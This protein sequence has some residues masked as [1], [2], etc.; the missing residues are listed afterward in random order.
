MTVFYPHQGRCHLWWG[1]TLGHLTATAA[2]TTLGPAV[3]PYVTRGGVEENKGG[4]HCAKC[5]PLWRSTCATALSASEGMGRERERKGRDCRDLNARWTEKEGANAAPA[6]GVAPA[7]AS[8]PVGRCRLVTSTSGSRERMG[9]SC[10]FFM[11]SGESARCFCGGRRGLLLA[12]QRESANQ[13]TMDQ[14]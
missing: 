3:A 6:V 12:T 13:A 11:R 14:W 10:Y 5:Q 1:K 7:S 2:A 4:G 9:R 8:P